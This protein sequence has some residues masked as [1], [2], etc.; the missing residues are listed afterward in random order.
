MLSECGQA[1]IEEEE[2]P[3]LWENNNWKVEIFNIY[4][5]DKLYLLSLPAF[6]Q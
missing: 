1:F 3:K 6:V 2:R 4:K 5:E